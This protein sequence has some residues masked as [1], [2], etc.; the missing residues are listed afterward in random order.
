MKIWRLNSTE[1]FPITVYHEIPLQY[2][3]HAVNGEPL[4]NG[5]IV[6]ITEEQRTRYN[7]VMIEFEA[8]QHEMGNDN[9][10]DGYNPIMSDGKEQRHPWTIKTYEPGSLKE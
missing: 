2:I 5:E 3:G 4:E 10:H 7:L 1:W 8:L 9:F 6:E